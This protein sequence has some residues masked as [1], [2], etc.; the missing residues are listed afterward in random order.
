MLPVWNFQKEIKNFDNTSLV[1]VIILLALI[2]PIILLLVI[3]YTG[4]SE[5]IEEIFKAIVI[6][7]L[8]L[9]LPTLESKIIIGLIFAFLFSLSENLFYLNNIFQLGDLSLFVQRFIWTM[10]M[11]L[12][13]TVIILFF[14]L[15]NKKL[16]VVGLFLSIFLHLLF[17]NIIVKLIVS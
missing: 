17:N 12:A 11:H 16:I 2:S 4:Y 3:N 8:I 5:I 9:K 7:F 14:G 13:T 6:L 15:I 10:P 1:M